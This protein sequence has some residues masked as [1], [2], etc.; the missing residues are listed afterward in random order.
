MQV[1]FNPNINLFKGKTKAQIIKSVPSYKKY[2]KPI[3]DKFIAEI[4]I[5]SKCLHSVDIIPKKYYGTVKHFIRDNQ[6]YFIIEL[7]E[8]ILIDIK[9]IQNSTETFMAKSVFQHEVYHCVEIKNLYESKVLSNPNPL[10]DEFEMTTTY[11]FLYDEAV[12]LWSEFYAVYH[13]RKINEMHEVPDARIDI[14][15]IHKWLL[16][17]LDYVKR[18][19]DNQVKIHSN[20][21]ASLHQFWYNMI[22]L[23]ALHICSGEDILIQDYINS[24][25][26]IIKEYFQHIYLYLETCL[27]FYP[28]WLSE[29]NYIKFGKILM[30]IMK[31]YH[32]DFSTEDLSD[33]FILKYDK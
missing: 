27:R 11:N 20:M 14:K 9:P 25:S 31:F 10:D 17:S 3:F 19:S 21:F 28:V 4:N 13:N 16:A 29:E 30:S 22:S 5:D 24:E 26:I 2:Y 32:L 33:N 6:I 7:A 12:K 1:N 23:I 15:D 18:S 8:D